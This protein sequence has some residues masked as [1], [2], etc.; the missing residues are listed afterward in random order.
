MGR[1]LALTTLTLVAGLAA[2]PAFAAASG[3]WTKTG[4]MT[5]ARFT[6]TATLLPDGEVLVAGG[7]GATAELYNPA[8]GQ[9][10]NADGTLAACTITDACRIGSSATLL[11]D[12]GV[13]VAGGLAGLATNPSSTSAALLYAPATGA[14]TSTGSLTTAREDQTAT[15]LGN[16]QVLAA[17]GVDFVAHKFTELAGAELYTP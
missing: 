16:G 15:L 9:W 17:G 11:P 12:G 8:T 2:D 1:I 14:W 10:S 7:T 5:T 6:D 3:T 13:L 4:T